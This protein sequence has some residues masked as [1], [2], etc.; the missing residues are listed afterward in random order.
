MYILIIMTDLPK[1]AVVRIAKNAGAER[2]G[3]DAAEALVMA[4]EEYAAKLAAKA[5]AIAKNAGRVTLK[6]D[7]VKLAQ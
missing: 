4:V 6:A 2:I 7:D 1:A 5:A 3:E